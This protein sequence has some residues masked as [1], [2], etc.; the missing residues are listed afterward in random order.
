MSDTQKEVFRLTRS[1]CPF[2]R[3]PVPVESLRVHGFVRIVELV[4]YRNHMVEPSVIEVFGLVEREEWPTQPG[5]YAYVEFECH[6]CHLVFSE[7]HR[8]LPY[9]IA[10]DLRDALTCHH[11]GAYRAT[12]LMCRRIL[13]TFASIDAPTPRNLADKVAVL[14]REG[15]LDG[16]RIHWADRL[17]YLGNLAAH[18][19]AKP[20]HPEDMDVFWT[21]EK[22]FAPLLLALALLQ[23]FYVAP[24]AESRSKRGILKTSWR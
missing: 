4:T 9:E 18:P 6:H 22:S 19:Q 21:L 3:Q 17:R 20:E 23:A 15:L 8:C 12:A 2:C 10:T 5:R 16:A 1:D 24:P 14:V 7:P 11:V 13:E